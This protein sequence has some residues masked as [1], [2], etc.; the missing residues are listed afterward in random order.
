MSKLKLS[1]LRCTFDD[2]IAVDDVNID[3]AAGELICLLGPSG[4]GKTTTLRLIAGFVAPSGGVISSDGIALS[5]ATAVVPPERRNMSMI[6]QSYAIWPNMTVAQNVGFGLEIRGVDRSK[7]S[8]RVMEMLDIV[9]LRALAD[10]YPAELSGGQ[11]QRVALAR[12][13][14]IEPN[15]LLL[16]EPLSNLDAHLRNEMRVEIRRLHDRFKV[17]TVYVTHDQDEA[18]AIADRI[19][20]MNHGRVEQIDTPWNIYNKPRTRFVA[21]FIGRTNFLEGESE[22][23]G[24]SF[25]GF[26]LPLKTGHS[27][28]RSIFSLRPEKIGLSG[29]PTKDTP[30]GRISFRSYLGDHWDYTVQVDKGPELLVTTAPDQIFEVDDRVGIAIDANA[31]VRIEDP[32]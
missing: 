27:A 11:Q 28:E 13:M 6:F 24:V 22:N 16:D 15:I 29:S 10:R 26:H 7:T 8:R 2:F 20:V 31:L 1:Q 32:A 14:V 4:C 25:Q 9:Q 17:T 5:T 30:S 12:A 23:G 3:V 21:E 18:M 19:V